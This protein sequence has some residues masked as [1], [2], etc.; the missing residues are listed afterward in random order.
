ME[1]GLFFFFL[2]EWIRERW[3]G[4]IN[5]RIVQNKKNG[6]DGKLTVVYVVVF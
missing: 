3:N 6:R 2:S 4:W 5:K 1:D